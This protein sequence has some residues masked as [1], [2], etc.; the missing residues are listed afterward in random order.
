MNTFSSLPQEPDFLK[1]VYRY[2]KRQSTIMSV[3]GMITTMLLG[4]LAFPLGGRTLGLIAF[5]IIAS[6]SVIV[7]GIMFLKSLLKRPSMVQP[8]TGTVTKKIAEEE[9][10]TEADGTPYTY[11]SHSLLCETES[12]QEIRIKSSSFDCSPNFPMDDVYHILDV[13]DRL[14]FY[15]AM[16]FPIEFEDKNK[17]GCV[18]C[19]ACGTKNELT[20]THCHNCKLPLPH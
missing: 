19:F 16:P 17:A 20:D 10:S 18:F 6:V 14:R 4:L 3:A 7:Y 9:R 5:V 8:W 11:M 1:A 13:G 15:P 12:G 2:R